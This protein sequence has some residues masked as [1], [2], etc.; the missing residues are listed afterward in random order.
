MTTSE[1]AAGSTSFKTSIVFSIRAGPGNLFR[2]LSCF[3]LRDIDLTKIESR[4]MRSEPLTVTTDGESTR[5]NYLFYVDVLG[6]MADKNVQNALGHLQEFAP[7]LRVFG[8]YPADMSFLK[9]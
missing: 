1:V 8:S 6:S 3:A 2:A 9:T 5:L 7:F 4:P